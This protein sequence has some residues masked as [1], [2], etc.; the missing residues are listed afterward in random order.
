MKP[1][2][3]ALIDGRSISA[4]LRLSL[5]RI[6]IAC[7]DLQSWFRATTT[8]SCKRDRTIMLPRSATSS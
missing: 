3:L 6:A 5:A 1:T 2:E 4:S 8:K 7:N